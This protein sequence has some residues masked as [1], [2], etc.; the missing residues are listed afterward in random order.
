MNGNTALLPT[1]EHHPPPPV[2]RKVAVFICRLFDTSNQQSRVYTSTHEECH[3]ASRLSAQ[4]K[5][6]YSWR[7][8]STW[9]APSTGLWC[10]RVSDTTSCWCWR[11]RS[12]EVRAVKCSTP[13]SSWLVVANRPKTLHTGEWD[14]TGVL[15]C[16]TDLSSAILFLSLAN[17]VKHWGANQPG[18]TI[19]WQHHF[20]IPFQTYM[21]QWTFLSVCLALG[22][23]G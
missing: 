12:V 1:R 17:C 23:N 19:H 4:V 3:V 2:E 5:T 16:M 8:I 18:K 21:R 11:N 10:R 13:S 14:N 7:L 22:W 20:L 9:P 15:F 6:L